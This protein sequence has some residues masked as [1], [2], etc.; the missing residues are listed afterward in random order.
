MSK[1]IYEVKVIFELREM[2]DE[3]TIRCQKI[4]QFLNIKKKKRR[5]E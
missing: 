4:A 3:N 1:V 5:Y 2:I